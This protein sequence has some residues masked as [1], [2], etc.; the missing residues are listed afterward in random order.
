MG[1][2][3][4]E[5]EGDHM[6][7]ILILGAR[8]RYE[9]YLPAL[10][11]I[12]QQEL[13]FLDRDS[14]EEAIL[15]QAAD[16]GILF[17]D[18]IAPVP[19]PLIRRMPKLKLIQSEGVAYDK[20][21]LDAAR[22]RGVW[23]CNNKGCN[24]GAVAE[25]AILLMLMLLRRAVTGDRA[26]R[27]GRQMEVKER[28]MAGGLMELS[29]CRVGLVGFGDIAKAT[30]ERLAP[31]GCEV[32]YYSRTRCSS[33]EEE[34][35]GVTY[36]PLEELTASCDIVSLHCPVTEETR[37]MV[38]DGFLKRMK[39]S[40]YLVNTARGELVDNGALC[41]ALTEGTIAGAGLD[42]IA[43]EPV[44]ADNPL[45][46]LPTPAGDRLV[47]S[48]HLGGITEAA[49]RRCH[50]HMWRNAERVADGHKPDNIVNGLE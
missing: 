31:F 35:Y 25:Q 34:R 22:E 28:C 12:R 10:P 47:L 45:A 43:P 21:D 16:A 33:D 46:S 26:V 6:M 5:T 8:A 44:T 1:N 24:A 13:V 14:S 30:A 19:G 38:D 4:F 11:F 15:A 17:A 42:T 2:I 37:N 3:H 41:R 48:P 50:F 20:I 29:A 27:E 23:V 49:F 32:Y 40:A 9:A 18:A 39:Q 36:L 7:K